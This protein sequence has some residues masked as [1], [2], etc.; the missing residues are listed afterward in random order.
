MVPMRTEAS[1]QGLVNFCKYV[2]S[3]T[4]TK[5]MTLVEIGA[6]LGDSTEIFCQYFG[7]VVTIDPWKNDIGDI[8]NI[9]DMNI[10]YSKFCRRMTKY[11]NLSVLKHFSYDV[12]DNFDD[13][14]IDIVYVD[15]SHKYNDV[16]RDICDWLPKVKKGGFIAGH[17]YCRK[18]KGVM[19]AVGKFV[20]RPDKVFKDYSWIQR[21]S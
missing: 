13:G 14:T 4:P 2:H 12:V 19:Q 7:K 9:V 15:G 6:F 3:L 17:D 10:I 16:A 8:T 11:E 1:K 20:G 18:F 5:G 21:L